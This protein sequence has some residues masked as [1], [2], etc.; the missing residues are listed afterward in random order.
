MLCGLTT[1]TTVSTVRYRYSHWFLKVVLQ[2]LSH[3]FMKRGLNVLLDGLVSEKG[4]TTGANMVGHAYGAFR[5]FE[6]ILTT[7]ESDD[8]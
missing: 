7:I 1:G 3:L 4:P 8:K 5:A 2:V 6:S